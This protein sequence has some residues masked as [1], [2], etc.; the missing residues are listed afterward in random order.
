MGLYNYRKGNGR[1]LASNNSG[2]PA[3]KLMKLILISLILLII[4]LPVQ[5]LFIIR[6]W[7]SSL[8]GY[9]WTANHNPAVW[10]PI[11]FYHTS[12]FP[13]LQYTGWTP[14]GASAVMFTFFGFTDHAIDMYRG[15]LVKLGFAKFWPSLLEPRRQA[16]RGSST[17]STVSRF[18]SKL[19][20]IAKAVNYFEGGASR[21]S[22]QTTTTRG[23]EAEIS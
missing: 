12:Q 19:D 18:S 23:P 8:E 15:W 22:S 6:N 21:K 10:N 9:S 11:L 13:E 14:V 20:L 16:L 4:Y 1:T 2:M 17:W 7:P 5:L 3:R